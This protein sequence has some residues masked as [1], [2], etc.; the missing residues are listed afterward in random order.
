ML[1]TI[2]YLTDSRATYFEIFFS[3][4]FFLGFWF[5][6]IFSLLFYNGH[7]F[8]SGEEKSVNIDEVLILVI[9]ISFVCLTSSFV[10]KNFFSKNVKKKEK[11]TE[12]FFENFYLS[13][14]NLILISFILLFITVGFLNNKFAIYQ[15][16][17]A[18][19]TDNFFYINDLIKW[20]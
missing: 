4:Y 6:Y 12:F 16:G 5:K 8:E 14:R 10:N 7:I 18:Y 3:C 13:N 2:F 17:F 19:D 11:R 20:L 1:L 9:F 15:R